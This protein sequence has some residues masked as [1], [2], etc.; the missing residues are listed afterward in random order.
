MTIVHQVSMFSTDIG[1]ICNFYKELFG[2]EEGP[3]SE[4]YR[5]VVCENVSI[6]FHAEAAYGLLEMDDLAEAAGIRQFITFEA[7][8]RE[9]VDA[10]TDRAVSLGARIVKSQYVTYYNQYQVV[11]S[12]VDENIFRITYPIEDD[13]K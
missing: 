3:V 2:L 5:S 10:L 4:I 13:V 9:S 6:G 12:D 8:S 11:I 7:I 1:R